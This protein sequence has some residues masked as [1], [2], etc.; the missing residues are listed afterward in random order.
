MKKRLDTME[1]WKERLSAILIICA[2]TI[3][4][5][6]GRPTTRASVNDDTLTEANIRELIVYAITWPQ[7]IPPLLK[8]G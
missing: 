1:T 2:V 7:V 8:S 5:C 6:G 4:S 3:A